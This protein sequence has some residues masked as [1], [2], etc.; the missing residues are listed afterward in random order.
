MGTWGHPVVSWALTRW[1]FWPWS[2]DA[3][4][5]HGQA[6]RSQER[7]WEIWSQIHRNISRFLFLCVDLNCIWCE[8]GASS[9]SDMK[10]VC[11]CNKEPTESFQLCSDPAA[12]L[13]SKTAERVHVDIRKNVFITHL[14]HWTFSS[15]ER[16][17]L[18]DRWFWL[19]VGSNNPSEPLRGL[20]IDGNGAVSLK[21]SDGESV[22]ESSELSNQETTP[23]CDASHWWR[24]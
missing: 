5:H 11:F 13:W 10:C 18:S 6:T 16:S 2:W 24:E 19:I 15:L 20:K 22:T 21:P 7:C 3:V 23:E 9:T 12:V 14:I 4:H 8:L 17:C 1:C